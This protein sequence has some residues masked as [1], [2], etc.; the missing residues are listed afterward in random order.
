[1]STWDDVMTAAPDL[2][3]RVQDR[4]EA[5]GLALLA[6]L[7][8][9]GSPR[10]S[11][12]EPFFGFGSIWLGMMPQSFKAKD[13]QRDGR[14]ALH[15]ATADKNMTDGDAKVAGTAVEVTDADERTAYSRAFA[16]ATGYDPSDAG[17]YHL[18]RLDVTEVTF[19]SIAP[20][21]DAMLI[22][23]WSPGRPVESI[24]RA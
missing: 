19:L 22:E 24:R 3:K 1:M 10:I 21:R 11:G 15:A 17:D 7:R 4:F 16:E 13:L 2:A 6:T 23:R 8:R 18:F 5:T 20:E 9:D 12:V 14:L